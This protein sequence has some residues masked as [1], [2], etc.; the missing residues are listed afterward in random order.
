[1][2]DHVC[3][4]LGPVGRKKASG[5]SNTPDT[6]PRPPPPGLVTRVGLGVARAAPGG[7]PAEYVAGY[8]VLLRPLPSQ[9][10]TFDESDGANGVEGTE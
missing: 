10:S 7:T 3:G 4:L 8:V 2:R 5:W 6:K 9:P 1:M